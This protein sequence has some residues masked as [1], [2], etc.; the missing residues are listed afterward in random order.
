[1]H[2]CGVLQLLS[3]LRMLLTISNLQVS[4]A[5]VNRSRSTIII[6]AGNAQVEGWVAFRDVLVD[7][8]EASTFHLL[9]PN[10][11]TF[12]LPLKKLMGK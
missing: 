11:V 8:N 10:E 12:F 2:L 5:S 1:M 3:L 4:E 7:V 6:P 9:P